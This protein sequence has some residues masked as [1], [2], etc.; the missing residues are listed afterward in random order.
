MFPEL[1]LSENFRIKLILNWGL[2]WELC[3]WKLIILSAFFCKTTSGLTTFTILRPYKKAVVKISN[4]NLE[5]TLS[6]NF[7][8]KLILNWG[9]EW[10]LCGWK[11]IILSAFFCKTTSGLTAF[12]ILRPYKKPVVKISNDDS[13]SFVCDINWRI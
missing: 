12:T 5:L 13:W 1:T 2:E 3:G 11:L 6:E 9:L 7:R 4:D 10:E 8:I